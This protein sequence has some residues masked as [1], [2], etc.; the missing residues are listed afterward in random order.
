MTWHKSKYLGVH[1]KAFLK[2]EAGIQCP[3][4]HVK[5]YSCA[6]QHS[7]W[8]YRYIL[9]LYSR[10]DYWWHYK[11]ESVIHN[12]LA[13]GRKPLHN[14]GQGTL[15]QTWRYTWKVLKLFTLHMLAESLEWKKS[16]SIR[17][18]TCLCF[19]QSHVREGHRDKKNPPKLLEY[20]KLLHNNKER[21]TTS[22]ENFN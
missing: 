22:W 8:I 17:S 5:D 9:I 2:G 16:S 19:D 12:S 14:I 15:T 21:V 18:I 10:R 11:G 13:A 20:R 1:I 4:Q 6:V 7:L 3:I